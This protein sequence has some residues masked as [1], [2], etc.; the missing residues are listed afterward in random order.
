MSSAPLRQATKT[1]L[2]KQSYFV[3]KFFYTSFYIFEVF[4]FRFLNFVFIYFLNRLFY[5]ARLAMCKHRCLA[6]CCNPHLY[7][8]YIFS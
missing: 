5:C 6:L 2:K 7:T 4:I 8:L 1:N 3:F